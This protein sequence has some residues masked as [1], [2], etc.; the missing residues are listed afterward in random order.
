MSRS[1]KLEAGSTRFSLDLIPIDQVG[2]EARAASFTTRSI[3]ADAKLDALFLA[4]T[5]MDLTTLE[6]ADSPGKVEQLC[7]R[8]RNPLPTPLLKEW[9]DH[10]RFQN[11]PS[12]AAVCVYPKLVPTAK[13]ALMGSNV[14]IASVATQFPAGQTNL[15]DKLADVR[16][17]IS[18]GASE[19]DMVISRGDFLSGRWQK[20]FD[21]IRAVK[22]I[23]ADS[24]HL[25]VILETGEIGSLENI[26]LASDIAIAAGADFIKTSTG[27]IQPAAT[28]PVT[29]VMLRA[30]ADHY[31]KTGVRIGMKPAGG[32][33]HAKTAI[34]Y[35]VMV[36][37]VL[38]AEWLNA[39]LFRFGAS[40]L[41]NDVLRQILK[42][43]SGA[44]YYERAFSLD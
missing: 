22:E 31:E 4:I 16:S 34:H 6:G 37:E 5:M 43:W 35:L 2:V 29:Y 13:A 1:I 36:R 26:R 30:I 17:A 23:C 7:A 18:D 20:V 32:I 42:E 40:S 41:L 38:G 12:V 24:A 14:A 3:K 25:K 15:N 11:I 10:P 21:E 9:Q 27:K 39:D 28:L 33:R 44:Y 19:I 8:A